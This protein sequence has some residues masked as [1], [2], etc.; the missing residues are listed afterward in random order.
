MI[1][2][3]WMAAALALGI[4]LG[5]RMLV[6]PLAWLAFALVAVLAGLLLARRRRHWPA[7]ALALTAWC[8]VGVA[9]STCRR[10]ARAPTRV[11]L[12]VRHG[13]LD[14]SEPLR[15]RGR[16]RDDPL[17]MPWGW[18]YVIGLQSVEVQGKIIPVSGGLRLT[19]Y[20]DRD[21]HSRAPALRA[22]DSVEAL[23]QARL[24]RDFLDPGSF[25][26]RGYLVRQGIELTGTLRAAVL[27]RRL[28]G[29]APD[30]A[31]RL[32]R[33][34]GA[35]IAEANRLFPPRQAPVIRAMLLGDRSFVSSRVAEIFQ[36]AG[37][38]H[39]LV[40]AGLHVAAL[41]LAL[42]W[43][44]RRL[45]LSP[46]VTTLVVLAALGAYVAVVQDRPP[47]ERAALMAAA[48]LAARLF[49]RRVS[50]LNSVSFAAIVLLLAKPSE[51]G[52]S[53]FQLSFLA[54]AVIAVVGLPWIGRAASP[55][56]RGLSHLNDSTRDGGFPSRVAQFRLELRLLRDWLSSRLPR[57]AARAAWLGVR[58]AL[59][60]GFYVWELLLLSLA[61]Q[62]GM[63][64]MMAADFN[65][66]SLSGP[67][68]NVPAVLLTALIVPLGFLALGVG[69]IWQRLG[70][71][72][73][74][75]VGWLVAALIAM[76]RWFA[77][78]RWLSYR[79]P[80]PPLWLLVVFFALLA[81]LGAVLLSAG[82][83]GRATDEN[84]T[85]GGGSRLSR[86]LKWAL[87]IAILVAV[88]AVATYPFRPNL[89]PGQ[90]QVTVLDV[91]Q[92][93]S[94]FVAFPD[95]RTLLVDGG[96]LAGS[97]TLG[98][99][100]SGF[101]VGERVVSPYLWSLGLKSLDAVELTHAHHDHM[102]GLPAVLENFHV[103]QLWVGHDVRSR[104]YQDL[105][106]DARTLGVPILHKRSRESFRWGRVQGRFLWPPDDREKWKASNN[107]SVV[108][109]LHYGAA[110]FLL[111]GDIEKQVEEQLVQDGDSLRSTFLKVP[112]HGSKT[113]SSQEFLAAV[114]PRYAVI[115]VGAENSFGLPSPEVVRR[116]QKDGIALWL[117][118]RD[119]EV[120]ALTRGN[121]VLI[122]PYVR[123]RR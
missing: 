57:R 24:P 74:K 33:A 47:V 16:L 42:F 56:R 106:A 79:I 68:S 101:D 114:H 113:S 72:L 71:I 29:P 85:P 73:A 62:L 60:G 86:P 120:T 54:A 76:I 98:G 91:G 123:A 61:I 92:G 118:E 95:G 94:I 59:R 41:T 30:L 65:R 108:L 21:E 87:G 1:P 104:E 9:A 15:W 5:D 70:V 63:L 90:M 17:R 26:Y 80:G 23:A 66:I 83:H 18:S 88:L 67:M 105:V 2:L 43:V 8:L 13:D 110:G 89:V 53:S 22:G 77:R 51:L 7:F 27:L 116:Y 44:C 48:V 97:F 109:S 28:P 40:I 19:L 107:D 31:Q 45:R 78:V 99:Y 84:G 111:T 119:G 69:L 102:G 115:S 75:P 96:G 103:S 34:R 117:T 10:A 112:H 52:D 64:P 14:L 36:K 38:Y 100:R 49:F 4:A 82:G 6:A 55:Y 20:T 25:D 93:D 12:L 46:G 39:V 3:F 81:V 35:L 32:A 58:G 50:L 122:E 11:D 121:R 37:A